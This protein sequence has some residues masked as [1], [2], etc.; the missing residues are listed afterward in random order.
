MKLSHR[1][2]VGAL[3]L[4]IYFGSIS[5]RLSRELFSRQALEYHNKYRALHRVPPLVLNYELSLIAQKHADRLAKERKLIESKATFN[6]FPLGE[7]LA[8]S[9]GGIGFPFSGN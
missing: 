1:L 2:L 5:A 9:Y 6:S 4:C 7:N 3:V 8:S